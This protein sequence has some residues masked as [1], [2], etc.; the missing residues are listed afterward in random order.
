MLA[1]L[2]PP[3][4]LGLLQAPDGQK[5]TI[6]KSVKKLR[7]HVNGAIKTL[8]QDIYKH[9]TAIVLD[10]TKS[11]ANAGDDEGEEDEEEEEDDYFIYKAEDDQT[12]QEI[13]QKF[14]VSVKD[15]LK[16]NERFGSIK[17]NSKLMEGT[18]ISVPKTDEAIKAAAK[19]REDAK[20]AKAAAKAARKQQEAAAKA[21]K[22]ADAAKSSKAAADAPPKKPR[23][24][25]SQDDVPLSAPKR[26]KTD[27]GKAT[28]PAKTKDKARRGSSTSSRV[29][30]PKPLEKVAP[31][32]PKPAKTGISF[33]SALSK[34]GP[35]KPKLKKVVPAAK[36][37]SLK[38][39]ELQH[40]RD[41]PK[42]VLLDNT[43]APRGTPLPASGVSRVPPAS[44]HHLSARAGRSRT[45]GVCCAPWARAVV[46]RVRY[47]LS[48]L[49]TWGGCP[50]CLVLAL[51]AGR[52][53]QENAVAGSS[54]AATADEGGSVL[55][56]GSG[57][58]RPGSADV[59]QAQ[60]RSKLDGPVSALLQKG[61]LR[62]KRRVFFPGEVCI[63]FLCNL[64]TPLTAG[65]GNSRKTWPRAIIFLCKKNERAFPKALAQPE[66]K[67]RPR[68]IPPFGSPAGVCID[69]Q[70]RH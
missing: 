49:P 14:G 69:Q 17:A 29:T 1:A 31:A 21:K 26:L 4:G 2:V 50:C 62:K 42:L 66:C 41:Q 33:G 28:S 27:A 48:D 3:R 18:T 19:K 13:A 60:K 25:S 63:A 51:V 36:K 12:P 32:K 68:A 43:P 15:L 9:Y 54:A 44:S 55:R 56:R 40:R 10:S 30:S 6:P 23:R 37:T 57:D 67:P 46:A 16:M 7:K 53:G 65:P 24:D 59:S 22:E 70:A 34:A 52:P 8:A 39:A 64:C 35:K 47:R 45:W 11:G 20:K 5:T 61:P 58:A 38:P